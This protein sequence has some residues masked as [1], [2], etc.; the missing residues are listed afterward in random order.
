MSKRSRVS[1]WETGES[2]A[3]TAA[4]LARCIR[5]SNDELAGLPFVGT[6]IYS[7]VNMKGTPDL[8]VLERNIKMLHSLIALDSRGGYFHQ[9]TVHRA[10]QLALESDGV[11]ATF[12]A[13]SDRQLS[14]DDMVGMAAFKIR[15]CE[16][17]V[18]HRHCI[19]GTSGFGFGGGGGGG[20]AVVVVV[21]G[22]KMTT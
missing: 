18:L 11:M 3:D 13:N 6:S 10:V 19:G 14:P 20:V 9:P 8:P 7:S 22:E 12:V 1:C 4:A 2:S 5:S 17:R 16:S 15:V 21:A